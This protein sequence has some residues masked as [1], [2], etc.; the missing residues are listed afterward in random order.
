[1]TDNHKRMYV[2][3]VEGNET[4]AWFYADT[5][6]LPLPIDIDCEYEADAM[7]FYSAD[8]AREAHPKRFGKLK[9]KFLYY[10]LPPH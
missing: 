2:R 4:A 6:T 9:G 1:M 5:T 10:Y 8:D 3:E 7:A